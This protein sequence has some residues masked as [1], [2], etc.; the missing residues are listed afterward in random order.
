MS[1][2]SLILVVNSVT[3]SY[4][5]CYNS[6]LQ[7]VTAILLQN[8]TEVYE[9]VFLL[10]NETVITNCDNFITKCDSYYQMRRLLR[11]AIAQMYKNNGSKNKKTFLVC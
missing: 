1:I 7:N 10:Q 8:G 2:E 9:S 6:I 11:I 5:I 4:L 3:V